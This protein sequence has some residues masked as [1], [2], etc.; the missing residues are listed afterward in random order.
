ML[1]R[2]N[3][4]TLELKTT[5]TALYDSEISVEAIVELSVYDLLGGCGVSTIDISTR[6]V[7]GQDATIAEYPWMVLVYMQMSSGN[8]ILCG[9]SL[10]KAKW[11]LTAG[12]CIHNIQYT[13]LAVFLGDHDIS[14]NAEVPTNVAIVTNA[15]IHPDYNS[16]TVSAS[17]SLRVLELPWEE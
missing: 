8:P 14:S 4:K 10:I 12:H 1:G 3:G 13:Q 17:F 7:G 9:G 6:I 16:N 5:R 2:P 11:V 15:I